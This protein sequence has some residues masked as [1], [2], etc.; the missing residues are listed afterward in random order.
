MERRVLKGAAGVHSRDGPPSQGPRG[1]L[2]Q[3]AQSGWYRESRLVPLGTGLFLFSSIIQEV[4]EMFRGTGT[5]VI[6]PF[7]GGGVD[8]ESFGRLLNWQ[9][10]SGVEFLVVLGTTG[11]SPTVTGEEREEIIKFALETVSGRVPVVVGTATND[12][13]STV[14]LCRQAEELGVDGLLVVTPYYNRP[15]QEGLYQHYKAV[16]DAVNVPVIIYNVPG[17]TGCNLLPETAARLSALPHMAGIK[18]AAGDMFQVDMLVKLIKKD[19]PDF[20]ILSGNDDQAFHLVNSGG[21]GVISVLSN[22]MPKETSDMVRLALAGD[23]A[24]A[25]ALH[26]RMLP[27]MKNLFV[28]ANPIPVKYCV[29]RLG[30]CENEL[31]LPLVPASESC[32][33]LMEETMKECGVSL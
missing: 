6:T 13:A 29:N 12:T 2:K 32:A 14:A 18:E 7:S 27:L 31:R 20:V 1:A 30:Y 28:E 5:A 25:R 22:M 23:T 9:I 4:R 11:E 26:Q 16:S 33:A 15:T 21:D 3:G 8:Y 24:G 17:R 10:E 19:R